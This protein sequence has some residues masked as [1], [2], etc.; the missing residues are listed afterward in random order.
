MNAR[1]CLEIW[2]ALLF[3]GAATVNAGEGLVPVGDEQSL[4]TGLSFAEY[5][6]AGSTHISYEYRATASLDD[7]HLVVVWDDGPAVPPPLW[8]LQT[9]RIMAAK[10]GAEGEPLGSPIEVASCDVGRTSPYDLG[11][12]LLGASPAAG[13]RVRVLWVEGRSDGV[14][15][16]LTNVA[17]VNVTAPEPQVDFVLLGADLLGEYGTPVLANL[18]GN[19]FTVVW[20]TS[21]NDDLHCDRRQDE[22]R[23][24]RPFF[25][26][27]RI[28]WTHFDDSGTEV[29]NVHVDQRDAPAD[30]DIRSTTPAVS[31]VGSSDVGLI[32]PW[33]HVEGVTDCA[34][35]WPTDI[36]SRWLAVD[37][38]PLGPV[39]V[40]NDV[41]AGSQEDPSVALELLGGARH[42]VVWESDPSNGSDQSNKSI[43][44]RL[45]DGDQSLT[46]VFQVNTYTT[47][48]QHN[49]VAA[50]LPDGSYLVAWVSI[51]SPGSDSDGRSIQAQRVGS[52]G[53]LL[54]DQFQVN[55]RTAGDQGRV[56]IVQVA[57]GDLFITWSSEDEA[58]DAEVRGQRFLL[59][60]FSDDFESGQPSSWSD[61]RE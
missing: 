26:Y 16:S 55:T 46:E 38:T 2:C 20:D 59:S 57:P 19:G 12:H 6:S 61:S 50:A 32:V 8:E 49:P 58:S 34:D 9:V 45:Y 25:L 37:G 43:R 39:Q 11:C 15:D 27:E 17:D 48:K 53:A 28:R 56:Q 40:V 47:S 23:E 1:R 14:D 54:G 29:S 33:E 51:G 13:G 21:A 30:P 41:T 52:D 22:R 18:P 10:F 60:L 35:G 7:E 42:L 5:I 36:H 24:G 31:N 3:A 4:V 44:A